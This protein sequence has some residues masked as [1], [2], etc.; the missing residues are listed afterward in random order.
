MTKKLKTIAILAS[1][2]G[3]NAENIILSIKKRKL[4]AHLAFVFSDKPK[5][6]V[7]TRAKKLGVPFYSFDP[8]EFKN[9][10]AYENQLLKLLKSE[11]VDYVIL[12]GYMRILSTAFIKAFKNRIINIHPSLLPSFKGAF[13]IKDA[14][15]YGVKVS[16]VTVHYVVPEVDSGPI[17]DQA[18]VELKSKDSLAQFEK[19]IHEAEYE[20]F[21]KA[22]KN[23]FEGK[24]KLKGNKVLR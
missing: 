5:A 24:I 22:L 1:G 19:R 10:K 2:N 12:A 21:P 14:Y 9:K 8:K 6:K 13:S 7:L 15:Q 23:V 17:I 4:K 16:G 3:A 20:I 11:K 18:T